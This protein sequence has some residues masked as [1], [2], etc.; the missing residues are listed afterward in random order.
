MSLLGNPLQNGL[1]LQQAVLPYTFTTGE[2]DSLKTKLQS[3]ESQILQ[4]PNKQSML[5]MSA[6]EIR[7]LLRMIDMTYLQGLSGSGHYVPD[8]G[9][10]TVSPM[11]HNQAALQQQLGQMG[12]S[13]LQQFGLQGLQGLATNPASIGLA[14]AASMGLAGAATMQSALGA[15]GGGLAGAA[16]PNH[17]SN[18]NMGGGGGG[19]GGGRHE[20][21]KNPPPANYVCHKCNIGGHWIQECPLN[22]QSQPDY[23]QPPPPNYICHRC[24]VPGH[25]IKNC[26]TNGNPT[27]DNKPHLKVIQTS[28]NQTGRQDH[29]ASTST[30]QGT[31]IGGI[32]GGITAQPPSKKRRL[33][34]M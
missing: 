8:V 18:S 25:W 23:N 11:L 17:Y 19:G 27:F 20:S 14:G 30:S 10:N 12:Q 15:M 3:A 34:Q 1:L 32:G 6:A 24:G 31:D 4:S 13:Q 26:P 16:T 5:A 29:N 7:T 21:G 33:N 28:E 22:T 9:A 2:L